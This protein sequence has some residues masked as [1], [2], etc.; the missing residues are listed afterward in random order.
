MQ[1]DYTCVCPEGFQGKNCSVPKTKCQ[2]PPCECKFIILF[3]M[4]IFECMYINFCMN[5]YIQF[6]VIVLPKWNNSVDSDKKKR[7]AR[8]N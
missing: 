3:V 1:F 8:T 6:N 5:A 7:A 4:L 2:N